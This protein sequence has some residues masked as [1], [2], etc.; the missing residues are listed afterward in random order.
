MSS[1]HTEVQT[2]DDTI[3]EGTE[4]FICALRLTVS[5]NDP[6]R[7]AD[8]DTIT[9]SIIDNDSESVVYPSVCVQVFTKD[10]SV[11]MSPRQSYMV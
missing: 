5:P 6:L 7:S 4:S 10:L 9:V 8:P 1:T 2:K 3:A 11:L